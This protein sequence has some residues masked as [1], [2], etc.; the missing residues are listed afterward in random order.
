MGEGYVI[1]FSKID[2][3]DDG[4]TTVYDGRTGEQFPNKVT[5]GYMYYLKLHHLVDDKITHVPPA[6]TPWSPSSLW[7]ARHSSAASASARW[8]SGRWKPRRRL[9]PAGD[10]DHQVRRR[11]GP[12]QDLR[13]HR[14]GRADPAPGIPELPRY[15][16]RAAEPGPGYR[17][18]Q[19]KEGNAVDMRQEFDD[20]DSG[21]ENNDYDLGDNVM[22]ESERIS[23]RLQRQGCRR[24]L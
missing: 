3:T 9:H 18:L 19:D 20:D 4:K 17:F 24:R 16:Q 2:L 8:K 12:C 5:V 10:P 7:A 22:V 21:F 13:G 23:G 14:Q 11:R 1:D 6:P 15:A